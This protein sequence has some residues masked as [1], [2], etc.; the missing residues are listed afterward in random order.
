VEPKFKT[1]FYKGF[2]AFIMAVVFVS[3]I[4]PRHTIEIQDYT[5]LE[6]GKQILGKEKGLTA[7]IFEGNQ[8][9]VPFQQFL[10]DK[11][12]VGS[13]T[14][15]SYSTDVEGYRLKVYLYENAE[16]EK[17]FD[18]S[19][20]MVTMNETEPNIKGST[21]KFIAMSIVTNANE[22]CL[23]DSSLFKQIAIKYLKSLKDEYYNL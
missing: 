15:V 20:F 8:R 18:M 7:F 22:D 6:N 12:G 19:Q 1:L 13:Y 10:A 16:I 2:L 17:Y 23:E 9:K 3:C 14:D 11:Y 4:T 5:L 21:A